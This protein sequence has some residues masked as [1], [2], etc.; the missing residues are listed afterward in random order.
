MSA[1]VCCGK[2]FLRNRG[3]ENGQRKSGGRRSRTHGWLC[4]SP[5]TWLLAGELGARWVAVPE[6]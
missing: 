2:C 5:P 4:S 1:E 6:H 3:E